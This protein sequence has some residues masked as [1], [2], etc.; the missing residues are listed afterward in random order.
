MNK[1]II[2]SVIFLALAVA[3]SSASTNMMPEPEIENVV[4]KADVGAIELSNASQERIRIYIFSITGQMVK[5]IELTEGTTRVELNKGLYIVK[6]D[7]WSK[8]V[9]VK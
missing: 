8:K 1:Y 5:T 4:M 6:C 9:M 7:K 3:Q 2:T